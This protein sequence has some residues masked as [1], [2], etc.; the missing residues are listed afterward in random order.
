MKKF[1]V[2]LV[3]LCSVTTF[4]AALYTLPSVGDIDTWGTDLNDYLTAVKVGVNVKEYGAVGGGVDDTAAFVAAIASGNNVF[5]PSGTYTVDTDAL[6]MTSLGQILQGAGVGKTIITTGDTSGDLL[7]IDGTAAVR[8]F[9]SIRDLTLLGNVTGGTTGLVGLKIFKAASF[10]L[11]NLKI[12]KFDVGI[13]TEGALIFS[14]NECEISK[15][16]TGLELA[17]SIAPVYANNNIKFDN[18]RIITNKTYWCNYVG[19]GSGIM[20]NSCEIESNGTSEQAES[21]GVFD[22]LSEIGIMPSVQFIN[23]WFENNKGESDIYFDPDITEG[24]INLFGCLFYS[25][26]VDY[27]LNIQK[28]VI[29]ATGC[30]LG[31]TVGTTNINLGANTSGW[32]LG[33]RMVNKTKNAS[34]TVHV[35]TSIGVISGDIHLLS[36]NFRLYLAS[37]QF[38]EIAVGSTNTLQVTTYGENGIK[39]DGHGF[40]KATYDVTGGDSGTVAAH[41]LG[42]LIP[43]NATIL[44]SH[45]EVITA[46]DSAAH[47][48]TISL[49]I[50]S[51]DAVGILGLTDLGSTGFQA[52]IQ[53]DGL[54]ASYSTKTTSNRQLIATVAGEAATSGKLIVWVEYIV[55]E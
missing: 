23:C 48:E 9:N 36:S 39:I 52:T 3:L 50:A 2:I 42:L 40:A 20:F 55:S 14:V 47:G 54:A 16:T 43:N 24:G 11:Y 5:V 30:G 31:A 15:N 41:D 22:G 45:I 17:D 1:I 33:N 28:G 46:F 49:G 19:A 25:T 21:T 34:S 38:H 7:T 27:N 10:D 35:E 6:S 32:M 37:K 13:E 29:N 44:R 18:C 8:C 53:D 26:A 12:T 51:D 4:G